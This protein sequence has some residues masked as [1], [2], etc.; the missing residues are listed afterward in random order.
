MLIGVSMII[1][2]TLPIRSYTLEALQIG[3]PRDFHNLFIKFALLFLSIRPNLTHLF[4]SLRYF[5]IDALFSD[6]GSLSN[7]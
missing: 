6:N 1:P 2:A 4:P 5:C 3:K 7:A